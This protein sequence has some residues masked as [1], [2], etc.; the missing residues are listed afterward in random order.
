MFYPGS[1]NAGLYSPLSHLGYGASALG[2]CGALS[3]YGQPW[4]AHPFGA[5]AYGA[6]PFGAHAY[7]AHAYGAHAY[8]AYP[9]GNYG[10]F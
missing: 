7:G 9:Y 2:G 10:L 4:G 5:H 8:G 1:L 6:H 3:A